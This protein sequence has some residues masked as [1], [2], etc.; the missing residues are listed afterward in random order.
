MDEGEEVEKNVS[1]LKH[2]LILA[3]NILFSPQN[4]ANCPTSIRMVSPPTFLAFHPEVPYHMDPLPS[5]SLSL[6][7]L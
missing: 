4:A 6:P 2:F 1:N 3:F 7:L 5:C